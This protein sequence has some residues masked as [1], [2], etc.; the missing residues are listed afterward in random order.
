MNMVSILLTVLN[1]IALVGAAAVICVVLAL[2]IGF[3]RRVVNE[4]HRALRFKHGRLVGVAPPGAHVYNRFVTS[5]LIYDVRSRFVTVPGQEVL[6]ADSVTIKLT[7]SATYRI[8]DPEKTFRA[9]EDAHEAL[10]TEA[11]LALRDVVSR[12]TVDELLAQRAAIGPQLTERVAPRATD[13]GL[14]LS[15]LNVKDI[16]FPGALREVFAKVVT[17]QKEGQAALERARGETAALRSL[18]NAARTMQDNPGLLQLR[19]VQAIG[20]STGN[21]L[22]LG[23]PVD[24]IGRGGPPP[25]RG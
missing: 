11:Q 22:V 2:C 7:L 17:A 12:M 16:T 18:A 23:S 5:F 6:T 3:R 19:L 13:Y 8:A 9:A 10:Y 24:L 20:E 21:T 14:E 1:L 15:R 25:L 4:N